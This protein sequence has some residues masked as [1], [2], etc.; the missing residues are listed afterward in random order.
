MPHPGSESAARSRCSRAH[1]AQEGHDP[2]LVLDIGRMD[3]SSQQKVYPKGAIVVL[4]PGTAALWLLAQQFAF[5]RPLVA[6][7]CDCSLALSYAQAQTIKMILRSR[8]LR[9][10]RTRKALAATRLS[11]L[12]RGQ[13]HDRR[14]AKTTVWSGA[15]TTTS[16]TGATW[17]RSRSL[18]GGPTLHDWSVTIVVLAPGSD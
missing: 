16:S 8:R 13:N 1:S 5:I 14:G 7:L 11:G 17:G 12:L 3:H 10:L 2:V 6:T 4:A 9:V 15:K 18:I